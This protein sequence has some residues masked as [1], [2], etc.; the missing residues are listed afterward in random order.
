MCRQT[1]RPKS[2]PRL[3]ANVFYA[4]AAT[5]TPARSRPARRQGR[6]GRASRVRKSFAT[7]RSTARRRRTLVPPAD[8][9][10]PPRSEPAIPRRRSAASARLI[11]AMTASRA[12]TLTAK[13]PLLRRRATPA[14][15][16]RPQTKRR[17]PPASSR[18]SEWRARRAADRPTRLPSLVPADMEREGSFGG[19]GVDREHVPVH[20]VA[21]RPERFQS[22][23]SWC[24]R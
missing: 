24:C 8:R 9:S 5:A 4:L 14:R 22:D 18:R 6:N 16:R 3:R 20:L 17:P 12:R 15:R 7:A 23:R 10:S 11:Q 1:L 2:R 21:S 13:P 19:V